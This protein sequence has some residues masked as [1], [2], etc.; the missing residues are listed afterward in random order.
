M[1]ILYWVSLQ[2]AIFFSQLEQKKND[3]ETC[4][5]L[6]CLIFLNW[7]ILVYAMVCFFDRVGFFFCKLLGD[8]GCQIEHLHC[9]WLIW[10]KKTLLSYAAFS[11]HLCSFARSRTKNL[12]VVKFI[13]N[14]M[15]WI[16]DH[17]YCKRF[18]V[19]LSLLALQFVASIA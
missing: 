2:S 14:Y 5:M 8:I 7:N 4:M 15:S 9:H 13:I 10:K 18:V 3:V 1:I 6:R 16:R 11:P 19:N 12:H 17:T